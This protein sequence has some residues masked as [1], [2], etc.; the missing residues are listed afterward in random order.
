[1]GVAAAARTSPWHAA[2][3]MLRSFHHKEFPAERLL[4]AKRGRRVAVCLPARDEAETVGRVVNVVRR[5]L[6]DRV[7]LVDEL[8]V[9]DDGSDDDT[10]AAARTAGARV[11]PAAD[12]LHEYDEED[13]TAGGKGQA[14]WKSVYATSSEIVVFC[15]ADVRNFSARFVTGLIGPLLLRDDVSLVKGFYRRPLGQHA[16]EGGR[17]TE[18]VARPLVSML[19]PELAPL[20]QP[21]AGECAAWRTVLEQ[22]PFVGGYGV[23]LG[24]IID[25]ADRC[26][27]ASIVQCDLGVR[28]HRNR[29]LTALGPQALEIMQLSLSRA[30]L[31][32]PDGPARWRSLLLRPGQDP[33][34]VG[35][36]QRPPLVQVPAYRKTA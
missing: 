26:G 15:D 19:F 7:P 28:I 8:V 29:P 34:P 16:G 6:I 35:L 13:G 27:A 3:A 9:V 31:T 23:D 17:V 18:L 2:K 5:D 11:L 32:G 30:G 25:V 12:I 20:W 1:V 36:T 10:A 4:D 14:L 22:V 33:V 21:L 24:L